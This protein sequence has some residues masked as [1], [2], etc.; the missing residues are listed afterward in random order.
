MAKGGG[1]SSE[2]SKAAKSVTVF[3]G[4]LTKKVKGQNET[5]KYFIQVSERALE[6][7]N[8]KPTTAEETSYEKNGRTIDVVGEEGG[9]H[10][11]VPDPMG[12]KTS[13]GKT[14]TSY[15]IPVPS[16]ANIKEIKKF[17]LDNSK[18]ERFRLKGGRMRNI[19]K[20]DNT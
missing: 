3:F 1:A 11:I 10:I 14:V 16:S 2:R 12:K 4:T 18:A 8:L 19:K 13:G 15:Q 9:K 20:R 17:L 5:R 6:A 7:L